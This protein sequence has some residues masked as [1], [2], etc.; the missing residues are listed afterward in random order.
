MSLLNIGGG[1]DPAYRYKMPP[2]VGKKEGIGNG[3]KTVIVNATEVGK[4]LKRPPQYL[5]KFCAVELGAVSTFDKEQGSGTVNGWHE[6]PVLQE[7]TNKF[8]KEWVLCPRCKLPE[9]SMEIGKKKEIMFDC[10]ACGYHGVADMM[11]KLATFILNNPPGMC[12]CGVMIFLSRHPECTCHLT[13]QIPRVESRIRPLEERKLRRTGN[14][15]RQRRPEAARK[16]K[17][18]AV[19]RGLLVGIGGRK[20]LPQKL[21]RMQMMGIGPW[22][23]LLRRL[24]NVKTRLSCAARVD[25]TNTSDLALPLLHLC[26]SKR[27]KASPLLSCVRPHL[28]KSKQP[29]EI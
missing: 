3:K 17:K 14:V 5:V 18:A 12:S 16:M 1:D 6:T 19:G 24:R 21:M 20:S 22:I 7:K 26:P 13:S 10:K 2:V 29:P 8:I 23:L 15:R 11:H 27:K 28:K 4:A 9:T 25:F